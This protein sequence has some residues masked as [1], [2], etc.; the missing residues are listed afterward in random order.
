M[1]QKLACM[2]LEVT[3]WSTFTNDIHEY[4][5]T[6]SQ[7]KLAFMNIVTL[8]I[9]RPPWDTMDTAFQLI[10]TQVLKAL[11]KSEHLQDCWTQGS[12]SQS[13]EGL[14][15]TTSWGICWDPQLLN[16]YISAIPQKTWD[17]HHKQL[18]ASGTHR[19][20]DEIDILVLMHINH[21]GTRHY[22]PS[23]VCLPPH[24]N[25]MVTKYADDT[26]W[27]S[28]LRWR[29]PTATD[30]WV[31]STT[32]TMKKAQQRLAQESRPDREHPHCCHHC[33]IWEH[34]RGRLCKE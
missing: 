16:L 21:I 1:V 14:W 26:T 32:T 27:G 31:L 22:R 13:S 9:L 17:I 19:S 12:S 11:K 7:R 6:E 5:E 29:G 10:H 3:E 20:H 4:T 24:S 18:Q 30:S 2:T 33:L 8:S 34:H 15:E 23:P 25:S 28:W